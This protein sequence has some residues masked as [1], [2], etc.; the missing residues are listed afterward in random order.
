[1]WARGRARRRHRSPPGPRSSQPGTRVSSGPSSVGADASTRR[2]RPA[3]KK[4]PARRSTLEK[5]GATGRLAGTAAALLTALACG[6]GTTTTPTPSTDFVIR[7]IV[8]TGGPETSVR[9]ARDPVSNSLYVLERAGDV[10]RLTIPAQG[11]PTLERL[12]GSAQTGVS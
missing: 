11:P 5:M 10:L 8:D 7:R 2:S 3:V 6:G 1:P 4:L 9:L 12:F